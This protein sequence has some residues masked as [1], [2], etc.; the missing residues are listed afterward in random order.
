[1]STTPARDAPEDRTPGHRSEEV[2]VVALHT[3]RSWWTWILLLS[4]PV[5][6]AAHFLAVYLVV[7]AWCS[8]ATV[9]TGT[10][11]RWLGAAAPVSVTLV[12]T[13]VAVTV[14]LA[15]LAFTTLRHRQATREARREAVD[16]TDIDDQLVRDRH[17]LF[18]GSLLSPLFLVAVLAVGLSALWVPTC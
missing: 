11:A 9:S 15:A 8:A 6:W 12:V 10:M 1:M 7:E 16:A 17:L 4:G 14:I 13:G 3:P 5:T 2:D 18:V